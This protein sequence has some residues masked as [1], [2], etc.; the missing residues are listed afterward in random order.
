MQFSLR[1]E[2]SYKHTMKKMNILADGRSTKNPSDLLINKSV[3][4]TCPDN[5]SRKT[6]DQKV[7]CDAKY[8]ELILIQL[9][10]QVCRLN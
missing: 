5:I 2:E 7:S 3:K 9:R 10:K 6:D 8:I 1:T 4:G